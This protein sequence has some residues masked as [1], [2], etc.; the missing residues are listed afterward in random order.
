MTEYELA[1]L[2]GVAMS[3]FLTSFTVFVSIIT[4]YVIA[5]FT[6]GARLSKF[7][8]Y[9][10]NTCFLMASGAIGLLSVLIFQ[11]FLRRAQALGE[12]EVA[13]PVTL[14]FTWIVAALYLVLICGS[15]FFMRN[16]RQTST[17]I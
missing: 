14:D 17:N 2:A 15:L 5:A 16:V 7:Q 1:D 9:V 10:V 8:V 12:S 3:N 4:A 11:A 13:S 6:A